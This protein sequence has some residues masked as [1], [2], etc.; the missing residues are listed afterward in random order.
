VTRIVN[1]AH[2]SFYMLGA[3]VAV[4]IVPWL[5]EIERSPWLF[6]T[7]VLVS[8]LVVGALGVAMEVL[9]LRR[10]YRVPELFQLLATFGVVLIVQDAGA[11]GLGA[12]R[13]PGPR[14]PGLRHGVEILGQ[15]FPAYELFLIFVGPGGARA[16]VA[17]DAPHALRRADPRRDAG[18]RDG[19]RARRQPGD[20]VHRHAVPRRL[21]RGLG[22]ALQI[23]RVSANRRWTCRSSRRPSSSP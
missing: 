15:R 1:F 2:G 21:P 6:F 3:Y 8:A 4:T 17:A 18:P 23:P 10:I 7:G 22:G 11:A 13:H 12:G 20:A 16:A 19:G 9:L 14:A 5:L